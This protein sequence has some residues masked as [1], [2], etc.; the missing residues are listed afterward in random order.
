MTIHVETN[1][2]RFFEDIRRR[3]AEA[4]IFKGFLFFQSSNEQKRIVM[5]WI[6][7]YFVKP[8]PKTITEKVTDLIPSAIGVLG[9]INAIGA[10]TTT[11]TGGIVSP[12]RFIVSPMTLVK[13]VPVAILG[14]YTIP[15]LIAGWLWLPWI[16]VAYEVYTT[17]EIIG[18][19][20]RCI[21]TTAGY[22]FK[23]EPVTVP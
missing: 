8:K 12:T 16:W 20:Y 19:T 5:D 23:E 1:F 3:G 7:S 9:T 4:P 2:N 6:K 15:V 14:Y 13:G 18:R 17:T 22:I 10:T 11:A 21:R